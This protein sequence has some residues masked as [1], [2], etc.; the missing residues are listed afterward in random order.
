[1]A[2]NI[3]L[4]YDGNGRQWKDESEEQNMHKSGHVLPYSEPFNSD[5]YTTGTSTLANIEVANYYTSS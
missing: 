3:K 5:V 1:M 4:L 2:D